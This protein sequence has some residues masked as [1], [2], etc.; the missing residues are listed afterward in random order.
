MPGI[1]SGLK[2]KP[3]VRHQLVLCNLETTVE[4]DHPARA[5]LAFVGQLDLTGLYQEIKSYVGEPGSSAHDPKV[6]IALWL[7]GYSHGISSSREITRLCQESISWRW[8][9]GDQPINHHTLAD[10][11]VDYREEL[12]AIFTHSLAVLSAEGLIS[13]ERVTQDGT[14]IKSAAGVDTFKG[15][16]RI[17]AYIQVAKEQVAL[18]ADPAGEDATIR[19]RKAQQRGA[20][21][22]LER[23]ESASREYQR[24]V[25]EEH[26]KKPVRVSI[27]DAESRIMKQSNGGYN[28]SY[29]VQLAVDAKNRIII[30][31]QTTMRAED[32]G[33]FVPMLSELKNRVGQHPGQMVV[34]GGYNTFANVMDADA[35][36]VDLIA[37]ERNYQHR[38][39]AMY[40]HRGVAAAYRG[41]AFMHDPVANVL[42]CP[43]GK[44]LQPDSIEHLP[45]RNNHHYRAQAH[46]CAAC[47]AKPLCCPHAVA[48]GRFTVRKEFAQ[49]VLD[50]KDKMNTEAAKAI[51]KRRGAIAEFTNAWVKTKCGL[52]QFCLRGLQKVEVEVTLV[53]LAHNIMQWARL[54]WRPSLQ[55]V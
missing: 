2:L 33:A 49:P 37:G 16:E 40:E 54:C 46:D 24:I 14:K 29:N 17:K 52:Q 3:I 55:T 53:A 22:R 31:K 41:E 28:P 20:R 48:K 5:I 43:E 23:L 51:Y 9:C 44:R 34:D 11:R 15:E 12:D 42:I 13:L 10:F 4:S 32:T 7:Y 1:P 36:H 27:T 26:P 18:L 39:D 45:G 21:Q 30:G 6:M 38:I 35:Y 19:K 50:F 47:P 8:L 25:R